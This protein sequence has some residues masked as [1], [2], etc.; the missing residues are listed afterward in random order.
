MSKDKGK[1]TVDIYKCWLENLPEL[2]QQQQTNPF[3]QVFFS[4]PADKVA[5]IPVLNNILYQQHHMLI[6][7]TTTEILTIPGQSN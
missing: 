3:K 2:I 5:S 6:H 7:P 4:D 1:G